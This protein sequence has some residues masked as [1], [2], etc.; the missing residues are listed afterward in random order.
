MRTEMRVSTI[1]RK[2]R[3]TEK[4]RP[5]RADLPFL[6]SSPALMLYKEMA[7]TVAETQ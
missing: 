3:P 6:N 7:L 2:K 1:Q 5:Q 4:E